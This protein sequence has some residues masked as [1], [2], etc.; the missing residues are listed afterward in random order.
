MPE[1]KHGSEEGGSANWQRAAVVIGLISPILS[2]LWL[3]PAIAFDLGV[4][5]V[6][7]L[8]MREFLL[9]DTG[10]QRVGLHR[11][12][13]LLGIGLLALQMIALPA[14]TAIGVP[15]VVMG[16]FSVA[17]LHT[18]GPSKEEFHDLLTVTF[19][20]LYLGGMFLQLILIRDEPRGRELVTILVVTVLA[21]EVA[22]N[23]GGVLFR[24]GKLLNRS[25]NPRKSYP[26]A[27]VGIGAAIGIAVLASQ[28][29]E[30]GLTV[31]RAVVLGGCVGV[32]CQFG[33]LSE[34]YIKRVAERRHSGALLGPE[35]GILDFVDAVAFAIVALR[36][37]VQAWLY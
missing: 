13:G 30:I 6:A 33:D 15:V 17:V 26:G 12:L 7:I 10:G 31:F 9:L 28:H 37:L 11:R 27:A 36:L 22:A 16:I 18:K 8:S 23:L 2:S 3:L 35:G 19:G 4:A 21:R 25:I 34:S 14:A 20:I 32:A 29:L 1:T 24:S 5:A